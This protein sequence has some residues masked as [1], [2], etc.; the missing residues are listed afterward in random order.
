MGRYTDMNADKL[1]AEAESRQLP[2]SGTKAE[3]ISR[4]ETADAEQSTPDTERPVANEAAPAELAEPVTTHPATDTT[5]E[6]V[7]KTAAEQDKDRVANAQA[8]SLIDNDRKVNRDGVYEF[9]TS[10]RALTDDIEARLMD[11]VDSPLGD[12]QTM[13]D[14]PN[15]G[16]LVA[17]AHRLRAQVE[18]VRRELR[19]LNSAAASL[20]QDITA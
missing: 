9:A 6:P 13:V 1:R 14:D 4:L 11:E 16:V 19:T 7:E 12:A 2:T 17:G 15:S 10:I 5:P 18:N 3:L 8:A 20:G